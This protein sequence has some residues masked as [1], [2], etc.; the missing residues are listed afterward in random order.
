MNCPSCGAPM[1]LDSGAESLTCTYCGN[2]VFPEK[3]DDGVRVL[4]G[5]T[6]DTCPVCSLALV[7]ASFAGARLRYCTR[8][9]GMLFAMEVFADLV[10]ALRSGHEGDGVI[11][12][13]PDPSD[14]QRR[15]SC[16]HC[17]QAMETHFYA[18]PGNVI[19]S[20][21]EH[22]SLD[23]LDHSKLMRIAHAPEALDGD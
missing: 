12:P 19:L 8:C 18:G 17:H 3:N 14:L 22:C 11:A 20:D 6:E 2:I 9:R 16:P 15:L 21:C 1:R 10:P 4:G 13:A 5:A 23:W 7:D